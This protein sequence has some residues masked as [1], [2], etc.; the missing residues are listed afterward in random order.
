MGYRF[1]Y[2]RELEE[3]Q[4][5]KNIDILQNKTRN[6]NGQENVNRILLLEN[7]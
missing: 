7:V 1:I 2:T 5:I 6:M 4:L 3:T